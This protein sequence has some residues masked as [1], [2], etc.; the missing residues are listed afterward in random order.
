MTLKRRTILIGLLAAL[1]LF[2]SAC[3]GETEPEPEFEMPSFT[4]TEAGESA[5]P[6]TDPSL[7][8]ETEAS[9][10]TEKEGETGETAGET[11]PTPP[12][13]VSVITVLLPD[14]GL[15]LTLDGDYTRA[16]RLVLDA[17]YLRGEYKLSG[18]VVSDL[19]PLRENLGGGTWR[20]TLAEGV[21]DAEGNPLLAED[22]MALLKTEGVTA[23]KVDELSFLLRFED[24]ASCTLDTLLRGTYFYTQK[25]AAAGSMPPA[26]GAYS[27]RSQTADGVVLARS[28]NAWYEDRPDLSPMLSHKADELRFDLVPDDAKRLER[29]LL[30]EGDLVLNL[31]EE[32]M[33]EAQQRAMAV[34]R[35]LPGDYCLSLFFNMD[36]SRTAAK[37]VEIRQAVALSLDPAVLLESG[38]VIGLAAQGI[39]PQG[40]DGYLPGAAPQRDLEEAKRLLS[41]ARYN[42]RTELQLLAEEADQW[43]AEMVKEQCA[44]AGIQLKLNLVP[45]VKAAV[46]EG[47]TPWDLALQPVYDRGDAALSYAE[48]FRRGEDG[49]TWFGFTNEDVL[50]LTDLLGTPGGATEQNVSFLSAWLKEDPV[51]IGVFTPGY[52]FLLETDSLEV[53]L[54]D[55]LPIP[56]NLNPRETE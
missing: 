49:A 56:G 47:E 31:G 13:P 40:T 9:Q 29:T 15:D 7:G 52:N 4:R 8:E 43:I 6:G 44:E 19:F 39:L 1:L 11:A 37:R 55:N 27:L 24:T 48:V 51:V 41:K 42:T 35:A 23:E 20:L 18:R 30:Q 32:A 22:A 53:V 2:A 26:T 28:Q 25:G 38:E 16:E 36:A 17:I 33:E 54:C 21:M 45:D 12:E 10:G 50:D 3:G 14:A 34:S 46:L 5:A